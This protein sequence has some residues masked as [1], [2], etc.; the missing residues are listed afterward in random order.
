MSTQFA[1]TLIRIRRSLPRAMAVGVALAL[2]AHAAPRLLDHAR[3][4][5]AVPEYAHLA[6]PEAQGALRMFG[7][8]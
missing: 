6:N 1:R 4:A 5:G 3:F 8:R 7:F 2:L